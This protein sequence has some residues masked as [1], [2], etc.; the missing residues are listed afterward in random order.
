MIE[1]KYSYKNSIIII[2]SQFFTLAILYY[3]IISPYIIKRYALGQKMS[4]NM[5]EYY[6]KNILEAFIVD[7]V[8]NIITANLIFLFFNYIN[9]FT[10]NQFNNYY[11]LI[12][13][14]NI[15][16]P[17]RTL[18]LKNYLLNYNWSN[19]NLLF[20]KNWIDNCHS[21]LFI[22]NFMYIYC[23]LIIFLLFKSIL[24]QD[25]K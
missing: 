2:I 15:F 4:S 11:T 7:L 14:I 8:Q 20:F 10:N 5:Q 3:L 16:I 12:I 22:W 13:L 9:N 23:N 25:Y 1:L 18:I 17:I 24:E 19:Q 21:Q 6:G